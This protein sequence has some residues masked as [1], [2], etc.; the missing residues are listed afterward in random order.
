M[1]EISQKETLITEGLLIGY[2]SALGYLSAFCFEKGYLAYFNIP[3]SL[4]QINLTSILICIFAVAGGLL[5]PFFILQ[6]FS[7]MGIFT[8]K[9]ALGRSIRK[10][11]I[12]SI[13]TLVYL[14][15]SK[16]KNVGLPLGALGLYWFF[17]F[18][19]PLITQRKK[20]TMEEKLLAQEQIEN[21]VSGNVPVANFI[22]RY[23]IIA[24]YLYIGV[25]LIGISYIAGQAQAKEENIFLIPDQKVNMVVIKS[26]ENY[27]IVLGYDPLTKLTDNSFSILNNEQLGNVH[28]KKVGKLK[29]NNL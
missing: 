18:I 27:H 13:L 10:I 8:I 11:S 7:I 17:E 5:I 2:I 22:G 24:I 12:L 6:L 23:K 29:P 16:F 20:K 26:Y 21:T 15:A 14:S 19:F 3:S 28:Q 9:N 25:I 4:I 1:K